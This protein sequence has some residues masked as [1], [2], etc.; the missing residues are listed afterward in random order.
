[1]AAWKRYQASKAEFVACK[2]KLQKFREP[3]RALVE[4]LLSNPLA[5]EEREVL[6]VP[7]QNALHS[8]FREFRD[9]LTKYE[10]AIDEAR[11]FE[12]PITA[13]DEPAELCHARPK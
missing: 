9:A 5:I 1:M 8:A 2:A 4:K 11:K 6:A 7:T 3:M 10:E 13:A 12:W